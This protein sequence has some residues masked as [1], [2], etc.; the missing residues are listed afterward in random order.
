MILSHDLWRRDFAAD[1]AV[2]GRTVHVGRPGSRIAGVLPDGVWRLPGEPDAW[3]L[4]PDLRISSTAS[5]PSLRPSLCHLSPR[6]LKPCRTHAF[7]TAHD[8]DDVEYGSWGVSFA[9]RSQ[10]PWDIYRVRDVPCLAR[11]PAITSVSLGESRHLASPLVAQAVSPLD[12][13]SAPNSY[14]FSPIGYYASLD[15]AFWITTHYSPV[16]ELIQLLS[17]FSICLF[18]FR[19]ALRISVNAAPYV[20]GESPIR[21]AWA[22]PRGPSSAG[23]APR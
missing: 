16:A 15:L 2:A 18:G 20:C 12:A 22:L 7:I 23:M 14:C 11:L 3:L 5:V 10:G 21:P 17:C 6:G 1:P 8:S 19:W 13:F 4:E 9:E